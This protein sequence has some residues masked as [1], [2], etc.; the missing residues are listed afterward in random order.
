MLDIRNAYEILVGKN[1][2]K[3]HLGDLGIDGSA[4]L[5]KSWSLRKQAERM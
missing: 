2:K 5:L 3:N 4:V 1:E